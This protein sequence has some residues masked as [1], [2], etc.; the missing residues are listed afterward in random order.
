MENYYYF[1]GLEGN[2]VFK[3]E[4]GISEGYYYFIGI[5]CVDGLRMLSVL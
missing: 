5:Q 1:R 3:G 2:K 4:L